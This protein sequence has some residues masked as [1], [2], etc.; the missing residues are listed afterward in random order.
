LAAGVSAFDAIDAPAHRFG[1]PIRDLW[2][3]FVA[4][5][6]AD[7][8]S[9]AILVALSVLNGV[10]IPLTLWASAGVANALQG[11]LDGNRDHTLWWFAAAWVLVI[12]IGQLQGPAFWTIRTRSQ[13]RGSA[14]LAHQLM[15]KAVRV[16]LSRYEDQAF[17]DRFARVITNLR[18]NAD[19]ILVYTLQVLF[20][21]IRFG[22]W[23]F[24]LVTYDWLLAVVAVVP[25]LPTMWSWFF[26]GSLSWEIHKEQT[27]ERRLATYYRDLAVQRR[28]AA[29]VRL[30]GLGPALIQR[31]EE[32]YWAT[33]RDLRNRSV[34]AGLLQRGMSWVGVAGAWLA[35]AW[36]I[37]SSPE[38]PSAGRVVV[39]VASFV[40][41]YG[42]IINLGRPIQELGKLA[43]F[44]SDTRR[45]QALPD[46]SATRHDPVRDAPAASEL[47]LEHLTFTYPGATEPTLQDISLRIAPGETIALV[48]EN[49]AG[50]TTLVKLMLGLYQPDSGCVVL[51]GEDLATADPTEVRRRI[52]AIFQQFTRYPMTAE[53]NV[54]LGNQALEAK[55]PAAL[56]VV[57]L[58]DLPHAL[59]DGM[60]TMLS[61]DL[62]GTDLSG[63]QWQRLAI[64]RAGIR[65]ASLVALDEPTA[66][67]DPLG[68]VAI[69]E[70]FADLA[71]DRTTILV[72]HRLGMA[73]LADR[74]V[75][76]EHGR[77]IESGTHDELLA[78]PDSRYRE[79]WEAQARWYR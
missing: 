48:G 53:E 24:I 74:I 36:Y 7:R 28:S 58:Q 78:R 62:G 66:G 72:S 2:W 61:P 54:T 51:D 60:D 17:Y 57:G 22:T 20:A 6:R 67:L 26:S 15:T 75:T 65:D 52:S 47:L 8:R 27:R 23:I 37:A 31:W 70:R 77:V 9:S 14:A 16:D 32:M 4:I 68:E 45:F 56:T 19:Y 73:R 33:A 64:A 49:G 5:C 13:F 46:E 63:G 38:V 25:L 59:P 42:G 41:L 50:K 11:R 55:V 18:Q 43:G 30:F 35:F 29:E 71:A 10:V 44:A 39:I 79:M 34:R 76:L 21:S 1:A 69:F 12:V 3:F 40:D